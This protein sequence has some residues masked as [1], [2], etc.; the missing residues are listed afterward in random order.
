MEHADARIEEPIPAPLGFAP[1]PSAADA[2]DAAAKSA[3]RPGSACS[4][5]GLDFET[6]AAAA[7]HFGTTPA[8]MSRWIAA[9]LT[10]PPVRRGRAVP[11]SFGGADHP[12]WSAAAAAEG[13]SV[14]TL[15]RWVAAGL[16]ERPASWRGRRGKFPYE[17]GV[18]RFRSYAAMGAALGVPPET[19]AWWIL[20]GGRVPSPSRE[21]VMARPVRVRNVVHA[22]VEAGARAAGTIP[23][24]LLNVI[25][26]GFAWADY[27]DLEGR[28]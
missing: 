5:G 4:F 17:F 12:S 11:V 26:R 25:H 1:P 2:A 13:V 10:E 23:D 21:Q 16:T 20:H 24:A 6:Q 22:D 3:G 27:A 9:G 15:K 14:A 7:R 8:T 19:A 18:H 28:Q